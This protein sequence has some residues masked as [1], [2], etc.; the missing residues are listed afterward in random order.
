MPNPRD[1]ALREAGIILG[2]AEAVVQAEIVCAVSTIAHGLSDA[3]AKLAGI[4][5]ACAQLGALF[6]PLMDLAADVQR[7]ED[8]HVAL[9]DDE[10]RF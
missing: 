6:E 9:W 1:D 3:A 2:A 10:M 5:A 7:H 8:E 4:G